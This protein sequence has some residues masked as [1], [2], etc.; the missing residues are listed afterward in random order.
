M[1]I[2]WPIS[3]VLLQSP[4]SPHSPT[5][6]SCFTFDFSFTWKDLF[7]VCLPHL[8]LPVPPLPPLPSHPPPSPSHQSLARVLLVAGDGLLHDGDYEQKGSLCYCVMLVVKVHQYSHTDEYDLVWYWLGIDG[9]DETSSH[10]RSMVWYKEALSVPIPKA[11]DSFIF[12]CFIRFFCFFLG[13][14]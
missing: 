6:Q 1:M 7:V 3:Q 2:I 14:G 12:L 5:S 4:H 11:S 13:K 9:K 10:L 8:L